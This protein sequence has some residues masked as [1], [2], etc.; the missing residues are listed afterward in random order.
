MNITPVQYINI[1]PPAPPGIEFML[2]MG[3]VAA[4]IA[5][6]LKAFADVV[7]A[8]KN[9][10]PIPDRQFRVALSVLHY[11][12]EGCPLGKSHKGRKKWE[13]RQGVK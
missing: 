13:R 3:E 6:G 1:L 4:D 5:D 9:F 7:N 10:P 11:E 2:I 8:I 12:R